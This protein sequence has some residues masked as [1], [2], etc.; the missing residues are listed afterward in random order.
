MTERLAAELNLEFQKKSSRWSSIILV[1]YGGL[2]LMMTCYTEN[3]Y[4]TLLLI[5]ES[6][7]GMA[8]VLFD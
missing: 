5:M 7:F 1:R 3:Y 6:I 8:S 2:N 4:F